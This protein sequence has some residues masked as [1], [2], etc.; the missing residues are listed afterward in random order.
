MA[1]QATGPPTT[2]LPPTGPPTTG[3]GRA[4]LS[5]AWRS[6][7]GGR[8]VTRRVTRTGRGELVIPGAVGY[9]LAVKVRRWT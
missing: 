1:Q 2:G 4:A 9:G 3:P 5:R 6:R 7:P 8:A